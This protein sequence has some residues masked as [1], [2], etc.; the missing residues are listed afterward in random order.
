M[1]LDVAIIWWAFR[2]NFADSACAERITVTGDRVTLSR[3]SATGAPQETGFNRRWLR[4][5]LEYD[6]A[7][8]L[9]GRLYLKSH[10]VAHEI[11]SFLGTEERQALAKELRRAL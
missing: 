11:A 9:F 8:E 4:V 7:R 6:E 2:R 10:G 3:F 5:E 1:G